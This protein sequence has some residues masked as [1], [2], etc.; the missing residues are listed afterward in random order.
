M[1]VTETPKK[2]EKEDDENDTTAT[3]SSSS[4]SE[5]IAEDLPK[6]DIK[7]KKIRRATVNFS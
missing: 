7:P 3:S 5:N 4:G 1:P 2:E 6:N